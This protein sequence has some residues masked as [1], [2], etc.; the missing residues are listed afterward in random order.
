MHNWVT[1]LM[2]RTAVEMVEGFLLVVVVVAAEK[3]NSRKL[4]DGFG[5]IDLIF[6]T[7]AT[8]LSPH[9]SLHSSTTKYNAPPRCRTL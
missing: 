6:I 3:S 1:E 5:E 4:K 7:S 2:T 9:T 8:A